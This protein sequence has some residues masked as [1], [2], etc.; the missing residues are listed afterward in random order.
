ML[1]ALGRAACALHNMARRVVELVE[2]VV[3]QEAEAQEESGEERQAGKGGAAAIT[4]AALVEAGLLQPGEG[5]LTV[6]FKGRQWPGDLL[7]DG[8]IGGNGQTYT[9]PTRFALTKIQQVVPSR[10]VSNGWEVIS[11]DGK[12]ALATAALRAQWTCLLRH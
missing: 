10:S 6:S 9:N 8:N 11:Y 12:C 7:E 1:E 5:V 2:G 3:M 4:L